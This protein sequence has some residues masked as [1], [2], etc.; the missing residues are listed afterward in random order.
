VAEQPRY[1]RC[2]IHAMIEFTRRAP[3]TS[4]VTLTEIME[5]LP[6]LSPQELDEVFRRAAA[7]RQEFIGSADTLH[8]PDGPL[9]NEGDVNRPP[10]K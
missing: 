5:E 10:T 6:K 8:P 7:L 1:R 2:G 4:W 3:Y 9:Q